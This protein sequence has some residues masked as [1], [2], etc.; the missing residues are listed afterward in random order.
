MRKH[1]HQRDS[2][3]AWIRLYKRG[4]SLEHLR[5]PLRDYAR[6]YG[7]RAARELMARAYHERYPI[8]TK[9]RVPAWVPQPKCSAH[10]SGC[11]P[12]AVDVPPGPYC[13]A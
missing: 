4:Y 6:T 1:K 5:E 2:E 3:E 12:Y 8:A 11:D 10:C 13:V 7:T 9:S